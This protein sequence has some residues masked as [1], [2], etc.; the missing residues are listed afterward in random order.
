MIIL[1]DNETFEPVLTWIDI[2]NLSVQES[3]LVTSF[4]VEDGTTRSDHAV[5]EQT[6][7]TLVGT[8][9]G[10]DSPNIYGELRS[11]YD[12]HTLLTVQTRNTSY[13][14]MILSEIPREEPAE[15]ADGTVISL[16]LKAWKDVKARE[17]TFT[18]T[19]VAVPQQSDTVKGGVKNGVPRS[20][21]SVER[22]RLATSDKTPAHVQDSVNKAGSSTAQIVLK[23]VQ[24][25]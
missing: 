20:D 25:R 6:V 10:P 18:V 14:D 15:I 8:Y 1:L 13:R 12:N 16:V 17:G 7:V 5:D 24:N 21:L 11:L 9:F 22:P 19:E 4:A 3:K 23:T 2:M